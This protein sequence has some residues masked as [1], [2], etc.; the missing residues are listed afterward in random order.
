MASIWQITPM[1]LPLAFN[2]LLLL[3]CKLPLNFQD[4]IYTKTPANC[5]NPL[6]LYSSHTAKLTYGIFSVFSTNFQPMTL[7]Q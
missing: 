5:T 7:F 2:E 3:F 1:L 6:I 4:E